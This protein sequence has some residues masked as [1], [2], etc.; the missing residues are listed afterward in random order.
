M[1]VMEAKE[2]RSTKFPK[3]LK[4]EDNTSL[5]YYISSLNYIL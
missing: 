4:N 1:K 2:C 5:G 3:A